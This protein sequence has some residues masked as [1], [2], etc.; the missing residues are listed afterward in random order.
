MKLFELGLIVQRRMDLRRQALPFLVD[1][2]EKTG[3]TA[4][5]IIPGQR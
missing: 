1:L 2:A 4:F 3:E 5:L